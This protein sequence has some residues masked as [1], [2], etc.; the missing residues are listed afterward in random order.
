MDSQDQPAVRWRNADRARRSSLAHFGLAARAQETEAI[1]AL[2]T[3]D[4]ASRP[5]SVASLRPIAFFEGIE[6]DTMG[7]QAAPWVPRI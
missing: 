1:Q 2:L 3:L 7:E 5:G 6:W 4:A